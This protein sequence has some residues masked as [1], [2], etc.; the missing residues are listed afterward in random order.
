MVHQKHHSI[1]C[2]LC[3]FVFNRQQGSSLTPLETFKFFGKIS[4]QRW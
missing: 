1:F 2:M 4:S 3:G